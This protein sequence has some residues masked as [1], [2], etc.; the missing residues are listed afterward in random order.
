[1][2]EVWRWR[3]IG[4]ATLAKERSKRRV[5]VWLK[6][7]RVERYRVGAAVPVIDADG[8]IDLTR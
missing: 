3:M 7:W 4:Q 1:M 5:D 6:I 8:R 2:S